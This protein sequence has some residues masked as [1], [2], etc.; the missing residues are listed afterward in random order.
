[1]ATLTPVTSSIRMPRPPTPLIG[2]EAE[3]SA[4]ID[5][6]TRPDVQLVTLTG[7][8]GVGKTRIAIQVANATRDLFP[9]GVIFISLAPIRDPELVLLAIAQALGLSEAGDVD[10]ARKIGLTLANRR[11]LLVLD[12]LE[13]VLAAAAD[14]ADLLV[15][16]PSL[17]VLTT[18][19]SRLRISG[20]HEYPISVLPMPEDAPSLSF[21]TYT[22]SDAIRLFVDRAR[23]VKPDLVLT[24]ENAPVIAE[25]C[26]R[27]DGLPLAIVLAAAR[28][29]V[30]PPEQLLD[31]LERRLPLLIGGDRDVP[32]R[33]QTMEAAIAWSHDLLKPGEQRFLRRLSVFLGGFTLD[34]ATAMMDATDDI[35]ILGDISALVD[36]SLLI[37]MPWSG[38][39]TRYLMLETIREFAAARLLE[40]DEADDARDRHARWCEDFASRINPLIEPI[41]HPVEM[42]RLDAERV[43]M[44][45]A[46]EWLLEN[47]RTDRLLRLSAELG[48]FWYVG[49]Y[50]HEGHKWLTRALSY[51]ID[52]RPDPV[53]RKALVRAGHLGVELGDP[54]ARIYIER[55]RDAARAIGDAADEGVATIL[56]GM[57]AEDSGD[58]PTADALFAEAQV[59]VVQGKAHWYELIS[60]YHRGIAAMGQGDSATASELFEQAYLLGMD[61]SDP[62]TP[63]WCLYHLALLG[64]DTGDHGA[65]E[66]AFR[67]LKDVAV[68]PAAVVSDLPNRL[69]ASAVFAATTGDPTLAS[70]LF[71]A[72][73][74]ALQDGII[75]PPEGV[76]LARVHEALRERMGE[77]AWQEGWQ[78]GRR[79]AR[80]ELFTEMDRL[81]QAAAPVPATQPAH[82]RDNSPLT[83]REREVLQLLVEGRS[84]RE[85]AEALFIGHR[86]ATTHVTNI[87]AKFGVETRAAAVTYAFQHDL[88]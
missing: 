19:R 88:L 16:C 33:Q 44:R 10:T 57:I 82:Q 12:N 23:L 43:N 61:M 47:N 70:R 85:I 28:V 42:D 54:M 5:L 67:R 36:M 53:Q 80:T 9:D 18:S 31:R 8:G 25:I 22:H 17:T 84:N 6:L 68:M 66:R 51:A 30:L 69:I 29:K 41:V 24:P 37:P 1:M 35:E 56:L 38:D 26:R 15:D 60:I 63:V 71:G 4:L 39:P 58:Y 81:H 46:L 62:L 65:V 77:A 75:A 73:A 64:W 79:M 2:R 50:Y 86:T 76:F 11:V 74:L 14:I 49:G 40:S 52:A 78:H 7:P 55:A 32:E 48:Y 45:A 87:L 72:A 21:G 34:A 13:Q 20:E 3:I 27:L 83:P 59:L